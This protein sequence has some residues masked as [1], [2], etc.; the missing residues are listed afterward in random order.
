MK[1]GGACCERLLFCFVTGNASSA[2]FT[3]DGRDIIMQ[4]SHLLFLVTVGQGG[5]LNAAYS[6]Y[7]DQEECEGALLAVTSVFEAS[8]VQSLFKGCVRTGQA[9]TPFEH[10]VPADAPRF[11]T[12]NHLANG[13]LEVR[14]ERHMK[15]CE[16]AMADLPPEGVW[17]AHTHQKER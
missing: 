7:P 15:S 2:F 3:R 9:F 11:V 6:H 8:N 13:R 1:R 16:Q 10:H 5:E 12:L 17:C 14:F 4:L